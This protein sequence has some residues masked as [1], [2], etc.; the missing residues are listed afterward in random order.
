MKINFPL[1]QKMSSYISPNRKRQL[2]ITNCLYKVESLWSPKK[3]MCAN[4]VFF[5]MKEYLED[6]IEPLEYLQLSVN[7]LTLSACI[8][9]K[10]EKR[11]F[12]A[13]AKYLV[14]QR[15]KVNK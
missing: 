9:L 2:P 3:A 12:S 5:F 14:F 15:K 4:I 7:I 11:K 10:R 1:C 6:I 13:S 8:E